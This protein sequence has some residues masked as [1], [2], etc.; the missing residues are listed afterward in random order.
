LYASTRSYH[1]NEEEENRN[2]NYVG[3]LRAAVP[4]FKVDIKGDVSAF[5]TF[6]KDILWPEQFYYGGIMAMHGAQVTSRKC[7]FKG[8]YQNGAIQGCLQGTF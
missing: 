1:F 6:P 7:L 3:D 4:E 8:V 5:G 2:R